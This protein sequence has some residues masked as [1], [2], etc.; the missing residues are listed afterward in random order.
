MQRR[1]CTS[2]FDELRPGALKAATTEN[3]GT[4]VYDF[5]SR[6]LKKPKESY[7][8]WNIGHKKAVG[9]ISASISYFGLQGRDHFIPE[10][11]AV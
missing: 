7:T 6:H 3:S 9:E 1:G 2:V 5:N 4:K 11:V 10:R 8:E